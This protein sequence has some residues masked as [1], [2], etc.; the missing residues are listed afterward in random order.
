MPGQPSKIHRIKNRLVQDI[1]GFEKKFVSQSPPYKQVELWSDLKSKLT[2][3]LQQIIDSAEPPYVLYK[4][5]LPVILIATPEIVYLPPNMGSLAHVITT[6]DGGGLADISAALVAELDR[7]GVNVHVTLPEYQNLFKELGHMTTREYEEL[8]SN[9]AIR[10]RIYPITDDIFKAAQK[11]YDD[12]S[13]GLDKINLRRSTAF[14]RGVISRLLPDLRVQ[15]KN[16]LIHC[17]DWMTGLLPA[18]ARSQGIHSLMTFHNIF[19]MHQTPSGLRKHSIDISPFWKHLIFEEHPGSKYKSKPAM[20]KV[21]ENVDFMTSGLYAAD[22]INTVSATFLKELVEGYFKE[23]SIMSEYMRE[24]IIQRNNEE[25]ATGILNAPDSGADPRKD[26]SIVQRYWVEKNGSSGV[27]DLKK[28]KAVNKKAFQTEMGLDVDPSAPIFYW[29]SRIA[30]PQKGFE[31][32]CNVVP[33]I[34]HEYGPEKLQIAVV[35]NGET[36]LVEKIKKLALEFPGKVSYRSFSRKLSAIGIAGSDFVLMP[37]LYEPCGT[38][39]VVGQIYGTPPVVRNTGGLA[40]TVKHLSFNGIVGSGFVFE[41][42]NTDGL[43][44]A[45]SEAMAFYRKGEDF[46]INVLKRIMKEAV[47]KFNIK[48]TAQRYIDLYTEIFHRAG[49][50]VSVV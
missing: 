8:R 3:G 18:A 46:R 42:F 2:T 28:G 47:Q 21:D 30:R 33:N 45:V 34:M 29:P 9:V 7:Q 38:P 39:Q 27:T 35:A 40:D 31:L 36:E 1:Q 32:V 44:F 26:R 14:M 25:C 20:L 49:R 17:N 16:V 48:V 19:T 22:M 4:H 50:K 10:G 23:Y 11:V 37:S 15:Y 12:R 41:D 13:F 43:E 24:I 5:S 6:G